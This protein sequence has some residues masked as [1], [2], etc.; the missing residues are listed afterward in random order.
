M[1]LLLLSTIEIITDALFLVPT[2]GFSGFKMYFICLA[3]TIFLKIFVMFYVHNFFY[4]NKI[5]YFFYVTNFV[6]L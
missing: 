1:S 3:D 4:I 2:L 6:T 5:L